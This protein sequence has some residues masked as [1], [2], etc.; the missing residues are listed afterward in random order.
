MDKEISYRMADA[1]SVH[2]PLT[3]QIKN[4]SRQEKLMQVESDVLLINL[5]PSVIVRQQEDAV[6]MNARHFTDAA[7]DVFDHDPYSCPFEKNERRLST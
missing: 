3:A 5:A 4:T 2:F 6:V 1:I 7:I